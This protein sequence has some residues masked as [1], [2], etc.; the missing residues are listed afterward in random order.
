MGQK[1][2]LV[3]TCSSCRDPLIVQLVLKPS[4]MLPFAAVA[5]D[6][7][8]LLP[9]WPDG[10]N[11]DGSQ[12]SSSLNVLA[13]LPAGTNDYQSMHVWTHAGKDEIQKEM[14]LM[15]AFK[16]M[17]CSSRASVLTNSTGSFCPHA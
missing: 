2:H 15:Y 17:R 5:G 16:R 8:A 11:L 3:Q 10:Q 12:A 14:L 9:I 13:S 7:R 6:N 1:A 4:T